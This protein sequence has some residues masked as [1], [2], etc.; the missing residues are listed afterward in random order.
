MFE[1][2]FKSTRS[3]ERV[4]CLSIFNYARLCERSCSEQIFCIYGAISWLCDQLIVHCTRTPFNG[5]V[6][7]T[8]VQAP[9]ASNSARVCAHNLSLAC[10]CVALA[11]RAAEL[12]RTAS[13]ATNFL[14]GYYMEDVSAKQRKQLSVQ[15]RV[16]YDLN[17]YPSYDCAFSNEKCVYSRKAADAYNNVF[18]SIKKSS[19]WTTHGVVKYQ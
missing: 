10:V 19:F 5:V 15:M 13:D 7:A 17:A 9:A 6:R 12:K 14:F 16:S 3:S 1:K 8:L 2:I 4:S 18:G 11:A